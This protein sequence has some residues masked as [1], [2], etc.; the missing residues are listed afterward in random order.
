MGIVYAVVNQKGGVGKTTTNVNLCACLAK[1]GKKVLSIDIDPQGNTTS[2]LGIDKSQLEASVYNCLVDDVPAKQAIVNTKYKNFDVLPADV[3]LAG[4]EVELIDKE[5]KELI[6]KNIIKEIKDDYDYILMDCPPG[7]GQITLNALVAADCVLVPIQCEYYALEGVSQLLNTIR[8]V[9][10]KLNPELFVDGVVMTMYDGR[11]NL[12]NQVVEEVK[13]H[14]GDTVYKTYIP[15]NVRLG[16]SPSFGQSI[17]DYDPRSQGAISYLN[18][19]KEFIKRS[20]KYGK[21]TR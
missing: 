3:A 9:K 19:T 18:L 4:A 11:T 14:F 13:K 2:G 10:Q 12:S 15:R 16:E 20:G 1:S 5:N 21:G 7:L 8:L 17:I 6:L